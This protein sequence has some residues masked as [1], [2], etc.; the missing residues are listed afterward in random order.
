MMIF[1]LVIL[2]CIFASFIWKEN[3]R[4]ERE[5]LHKMI[6]G[7]IAFLAGSA[8]LVIGIVLQSL[9][10]QLDVWLVITL[11]VMILAKA[12]GLIYSRVKQ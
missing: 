7:R 11:V 8:V 3:A 12:A 5:N 1:G 4:D 6:A 10:H 2:F 9:S